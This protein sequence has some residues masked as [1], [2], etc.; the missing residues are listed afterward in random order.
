MISDYAKAST[1]Q[2]GI[3]KLELVDST[4]VH[5]SV[6]IKT[7]LGNTERSVAAVLRVTGSRLLVRLAVTKVLLMFTTYPQS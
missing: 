2:D 1:K 5:A 4:F 6:F 7:L 3:P